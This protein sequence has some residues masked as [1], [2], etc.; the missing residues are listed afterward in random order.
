M[1]NRVKESGIII[2]LAEP[3]EHTIAIKKK[4][5]FLGAFMFDSVSPLPE[6][7]IPLPY[8]ISFVIII[9]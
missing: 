9:R 2:I 1:H 5:H 8:S 6:G 3:C 4:M 7:V